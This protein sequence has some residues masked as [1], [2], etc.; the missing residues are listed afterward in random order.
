[1]SVP[2]VELTSEEF[3]FVSKAV[4]ELPAEVHHGEPSTR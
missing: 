4:R 1:M 3:A 2:T